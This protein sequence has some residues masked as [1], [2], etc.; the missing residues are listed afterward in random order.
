MRPPG[1][2]PVTFHPRALVR[3]WRRMQRDPLLR[4]RER[5]ERY[6]DVYRIA[7]LGRERFVLRHPAHLQEVLI[8]QAARF[9]K[10]H[11]GPAARQLQRFLGQGLLTSNGELWRRQ[12]RLIQ[13]AF[14][15]E[16]LAGY[17]DVVVA[18]TE[19]ALSGLR[20]GQRLDLSQLM[21]ELTLRIVNGTLFGREPEHETRRVGRAMQAF[22]ETFDGIGAILPRWLPTPGALRAGR[23]LRDMDALIFGWIDAPRDAR[24]RDLLTS[25]A[26]ALDRE[27]AG[28]GMQRRQ[29]RD[30]LLTLLLAGHETTSHA[31]SWTFHLLAQH[32]EVEARLHAELARVLA[33]RAPRAADLPNLPYAEQVLSEALRLYPPAYVVLRSAREPAQVAGYHVPAGTD[34]VLWIYHTHHDARWYHEPERF[35]PDRFSAARR[36]QLPACAYVPFGAGTRTCIGKNFAL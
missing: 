9:E 6:G 3:Q 11:T 19:R 4:V 27:G 24:R 17:A 35:D 36:K 15:R 10:P 21:M 22:R 28:A 1:P 30:E 33:G 31:L 5:F 7:F 16:Q 18:E 13:P 14:Q 32:P 29:L 26:G 23:A 20:H 34:M 12:R 25:L 8:D 2:A